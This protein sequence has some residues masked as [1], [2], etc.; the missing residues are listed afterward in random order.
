MDIHN[1]LKQLN[2]SSR[3]KRVQ[4]QDSIGCVIEKKNWRTWL[5]NF[6]AA[7]QV[8]MIQYEN[9]LEYKDEQEDSPSIIYPLY[10]GSPS[11]CYQH[12]S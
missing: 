2:K 1:W 7:Q 3:E 5:K 12:T 9:K 6:F 11:R 10:L 4:T 8:Q